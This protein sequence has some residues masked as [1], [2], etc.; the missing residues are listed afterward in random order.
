[1]TIY[2]AESKSLSWPREL[3]VAFFLAFLIAYLAFLPTGPYP[4]MAGGLRVEYLLFCAV[5][6]TS[7]PLLRSSF[8][9]MTGNYAWVQLCSLW[10]VVTIGL[11]TFLSSDPES[12][13][14]AFGTTVGY[15][16]LMFIVPPLIHQHMQL[17]R[18]SLLW[19]AAATACLL[20][21]LNV[22]LGYGT[23]QRFAL[24]ESAEYVPGETSYVDPNMTAIGMLLCL[25][26]SLP[27]LW[28]AEQQRNWLYKFFYRMLLTMVLGASFLFISRTAALSLVIAIIFGLIRAKNQG[29][30]LSTIW[31]RSIPVLVIL[32]GAAIWRKDDLGRV[33]DRTVNFR[34]E[35]VYATSRTD[36]FK[37]AWDSWLSSTKTVI[38]G[39]GYYSTNP[40]NELLRTL[41][42]DGLLGLIALLALLFSV[43]LTCC[44]KS[45]FTV[46][47]RFN[48]NALFAFIL[49]AM[50]TYGHTKTM[51]LTFMFLLAGYLEAKNDPKNGWRTAVIQ[52]NSP[53]PVGWSLNAHW[54]PRNGLLRQE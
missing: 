50:M 8:R 51:W 13:N 18:K 6:V 43:Y 44:R 5:C 48:Q 21:Y 33:V 34:D 30:H 9:Q 53:K 35:E 28:A 39:T 7:L 41:V 47:Q 49:S 45:H 26:M 37:T 14:R 54:A 32:V 52:P 17:L 3:C 46:G 40:H 4:L 20:L 36:L 29:L 23:T 2:T 11:T 1:M 22:V 27:L 31:R 16:Y 12:S 24:S 15:A 25:V 42:G 19:M 10:Y 38:V